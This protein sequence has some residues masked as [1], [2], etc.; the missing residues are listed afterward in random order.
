MIQ[1]AEVQCRH[2]ASH[3]KPHCIAQVV[4]YS[5][6]DLGEPSSHFEEMSAGF[7][8]RHWFILDL[9]HATVTPA[10]YSTPNTQIAN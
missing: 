1:D 9:V 8:T 5:T 2:R 7:R 6:R 3:T 4:L 10:P